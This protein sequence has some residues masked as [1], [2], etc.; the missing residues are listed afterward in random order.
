MAGRIRSLKPEIN[1]DQ[2]LATCSDTANLLFD[3]GITLAD[4]HGNL[5]ADADYLRGQVWWKREPAKPIADALAE[6]AKAGLWTVYVI[7][8]QT[9]AHINGWSKHQRIDNAN[10]PRLPLPPGWVCEQESRKEGNRVRTRW[11]SKLVGSGAAPTTTTIDPGA[12]PIPPRGHAPELGPLDHYHDHDHEG[13]GAVAAG[14]APAPTHT[15]APGPA[16]KPDAS[17]VRTELAKADDLWPDDDTLTKAARRIADNVSDPMNRAKGEHVA[18]T[19]EAITHARAFRTDKTLAT[20]DRLL[21]EAEKKVG[22]ILA[23]YRTGKRQKAGA[24]APDKIGSHTVTE[25]FHDHER[26]EMERTAR[27]AEKRRAEEAPPPTPEERRRMLAD[28]NK[29]IGSGGRAA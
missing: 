15:P 24:V 9:Y 5:R 7:N 14:A 11:V 20:A 27:E 13:S 1:E 3:R 23:D 18:V 8:G 21:A 29:R 2:L 12:A 16:L 19:R 10:E 4:D 22:W 6:L 28:L 26:A 17:Q 25:D